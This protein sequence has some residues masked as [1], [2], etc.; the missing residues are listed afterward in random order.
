MK[1]GLFIHKGILNLACLYGALLDGQ[2]V[3][4]PLDG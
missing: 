3:E 1:G 4:S 2:G